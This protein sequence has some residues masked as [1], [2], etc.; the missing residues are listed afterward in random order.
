MRLSSLFLIASAACGC[1]RIAVMEGT[2]FD[3]PSSTT[4]MAGADLA[5]LE[6][7]GE[8]LVSTVT[9]NAGYFDVEV[10]MGV[11]VHMEVS[12]DGAVTSSFYGETGY[13]PLFQV[14]DGELFGLP[15]S[16]FD[17]WE[18]LFTGCPGVGEPGGVLLGEMRVYDI[19]S[20][21]DGTN[22]LVTTG[23]VWVENGD[24]RLDACYL[25]DEGLAYDPSTDRTGDSGRFAIFGIPEGAWDVALAY[26]PYTG[27]STIS[28]HSLYVSE[29]TVAPLLPAWVE[30]TFN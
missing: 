9:D 16:E 1:T 15:Q 7:D 29:G 17:T 18:A 4:P 3:G 19:T 23:F 21:V 22:P 8:I 24:A 14:A 27:R 6:E 25:D 20:A 28:G 26:N 11:P 30:F 2:V 13:Q 12:G 10:P 5:L